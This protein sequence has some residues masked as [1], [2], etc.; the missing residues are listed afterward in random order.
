MVSP[1]PNT[2]ESQAPATGETGRPPS[3][4]MGSHGW[5]RIV[6]AVVLL[7]ALATVVVRGIYVV[8]HL[9]D[10]KKE[11]IQVDAPAP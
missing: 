10:Y 4:K 8:A 1:T 6:M 9:D 11:T 5:S 2:P 7:G 3:P